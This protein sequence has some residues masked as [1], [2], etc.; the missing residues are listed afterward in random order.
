MTVVVKSSTDEVIA[1]PPWIMRLLNLHE[2]NKI[3]PIIEGRMVR[4][5]P[6]DQFLSLR[7]A[8]REDRDFDAAIE[9]LNQRWQS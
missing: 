8:L 5:T 1:L 7:G 6:L 2:G 4:L 9:S 3:K